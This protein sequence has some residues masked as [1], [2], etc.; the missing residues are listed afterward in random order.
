ME[1]CKR[2]IALGFFDGVHLGHGELLKRTKERAAE[3]NAMPSVLSFDVHPDTLVFG[4]DVKLISSATDREE[5]I[6]RCYGID[7]IVFLHFNRHMMCMPW[8]EFVDN[9]V[10]QLNVSWIVMGH[11]FS[12]GYRGEGKAE[13]IRDYCAPLGIGCDIIPPLCMDGRVISSTWIRELISSGDMENAQKLLGHPHT[14]SDTVHSGYHL[15]RKLGT[16]TINMF[17]PDGVLIPKFGVYASKA[18]IDGESYLAVT[19][20]GIRPTVENGG[21]VSVESHLLNYSGN[22]YGRQAR[23][24]FYKFLRPETK[25]ENFEKLSEQIHRDSK[26]AEEYF[27]TEARNTTALLP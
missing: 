22:L 18:Y 27:K 10:A 23:V 17:F 19:N 9:I 15:G 13:L 21:R 2:V 14:L 6:R 25:F 3:I 8:R 20:I 26:A 5:I 16:P 1:E 11:D 7:N 24:E 4:S 12:C